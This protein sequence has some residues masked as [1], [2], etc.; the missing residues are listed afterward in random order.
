MSV[1]ASGYPWIDVT[2]LAFAVAVITLTVAL[3]IWAYRRALRSE[4]KVA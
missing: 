2:G 1:A 3:N 4:I